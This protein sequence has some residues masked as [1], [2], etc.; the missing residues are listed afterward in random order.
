M[1]ERKVTILCDI[2]SR[3]SLPSD[4]LYT[5]RCSMLFTAPAST[6]Q[7]CPLWVEETC[8]A[9]SDQTSR[10]NFESIKPPFC[11]AFF[12]GGLLLLHFEA[13]NQISNH[14]ARMR[15]TV[16]EHQLHFELGSGYDWDEAVAEI[17][18]DDSFV[19]IDI[20]ECWDH[21]QPAP[22]ARWFCRLCE[23]RHVEYE[24]TTR[25]LVIVTNANESMRCVIANEDDMAGRAQTFSNSWQT[26]NLGK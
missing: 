3:M 5:R 10:S 7:H 22:L 19:W 8:S 4:P 13:R 21:S 23:L 15:G 20:G 2:L 18:W 9:T 16:V 26:Q 25:Q 6:V 1:N 11:R 12:W 24:S 17:E 14:T